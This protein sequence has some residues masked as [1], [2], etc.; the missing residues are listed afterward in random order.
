MVITASWEEDLA[1]VVF[2]S[3]KFVFLCNL[4]VLLSQEK[5]SFASV[6][7]FGDNKSA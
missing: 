6:G 1:A 4:I 2:V 5:F 7:L 3:S